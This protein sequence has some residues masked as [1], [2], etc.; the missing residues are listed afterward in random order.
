LKALSAK[1]LA[2]GTAG[3]FFLLILAAMLALQ[4]DARASHEGGMDA[5]SIDLDVAGNTATTLGPRDECLEVSP[6][7][8]L[9]L[10]VTAEGIPAQYPMIAFSFQ[11][12]HTPDAFS[13]DG[14]SSD[15]LLAALPGSQLFDVSQPT[16]DAGG[17]WTAAAADTAT[18]DT[19]ETGSGVLSRV[20]LSVNVV[21]P[22]GL[23]TLTLTSAAHV[24]PF[25]DAFQPRAL[26]W[27][28][29]AVGVPCENL[30]T[31]PPTPDV[32]HS[33]TLPPPTYGPTSTPY[34]PP[35]PPPGALA[36]VGFDHD[37]GSP[38]INDNILPILTPGH[39]VKVGL[40]VEP[41][42]GVAVGAWQM[43]VRFQSSVVSVVECTGFQ[44]TV[45]NGDYAP[46]EVRIAGA[47]LVGVS[48]PTR[49]IELTFEAAT[50]QNLCTSLTVTEAM[51]ADNYGVD[52]ET[53]LYTG[54]ICVSNHSNPTLPPFPSPTPGGT[55]G[56]T[57]PPGGGP[58]VF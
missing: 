4:G 16:P 27:A 36:L 15:F 43:V 58:P 24:D 42:G 35:T 44:G 19:A 47:S 28:W 7:D 13:V 57:P 10:D 30:P 52:L 5:M 37:G 2:A 3:F 40:V 22:P 29:L 25:T 12:G 17:E 20:D 53:F 54:T 41:Q 1:R 8:T 31:Q 56:P 23:Y 49:L 51:V 46:N 21:T 34:I 48:E 6:G 18:P 26:N 45:C 50:T 55:A 32:S 14:S 33:P 9:T 38:D 11:L 39:T